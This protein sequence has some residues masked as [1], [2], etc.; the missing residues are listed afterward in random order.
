MKL[1]TLA[2]LVLSANAEEF[3]VKVGSSINS[4]L[5]KANPGDTVIL[6]DGVHKQDIK[7][8]R[9][10]KADN[11]ITIKGSRK[12]IVNGNKDSRM[13][14]I[15]HSYIQLE[16]F[17]ADG[18]Q[19]SGDKVDDFVD[20]GVYVLGTKKPE[21]IRDDKGEY[22]SSIDGFKLT[23]VHVLNFGGEC[24]RLRSFITNA[25][26]MGNMI[27]NCGV[28]DFQFPSSTVN[29]EAI[30]VGCSSNQWMDGKNSKPGPDLTKYIHIHHNEIIPRG[31]ECVDVKE[32]TTM[33]LVEYNICSEQ[34]DENSAGLD[35]RA[36]NVIF[37]Y[38]EV[39][40]VKGAGVRIGGHTIDGHTYGENNEV[41]GNVFFNTAY[42][43]VKTLTGSKHI[44]CENTCRDKCSIAGSMSKSYTSI[45][46]KCPSSSKMIDPVWTTPGKIL[47]I[48]DEIR[49]NGE[50]EQDANEGPK[51]LIEDEE[52][53]NNDKKVVKSD[54]KCSPVKI[55]SVKA[56]DHDGNTPQ[57]AIDGKAASRWST[58][59]IGSWLEMELQY[60]SKVDSVEMAF[61][62]GDTR[63][64]YFDVYGNGEPLIK[65]AKSSG[66]TLGLERF[67]IKNPKEVTKVTIFGNGNSKNSW[68]SL[69]EIIVCGESDTD[70][71]DH[72]SPD[73]DQCETK[74]LDIKGVSASGSD[75]NSPENVLKED[76]NRWSCKESPCELIFS[77]TGEEDVKEMSFVVYKGKD[78]IQYFDVE[79]ELESGWVTVIQDGSS[80]KN[81]GLQSVD[82][83]VSDV[84]SVKFIGYGCDVTD[85]NSINYVQLTGCKYNE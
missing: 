57:N 81:N 27:E 36:D 24:V 22:E 34:L 78:R 29:G 70:H 44:M 77:L 54:T 25:E 26:V 47:D 5:E 15:N 39:F 4:V 21:I 30:Y 23:N 56:S 76:N 71:T 41:Y 31:N 16:G 53:E 7:S 38:N 82:I 59:K 80:V 58:E 75:G 40:N 10:G 83:N 50:E 33:V 68:S 3:R 49:G 35:S 52:N 19:G 62:K 43:S 28:H 17:T 18:K 8:V 69:T 20:K 14:Q 85:W 45:D 79:V 63:Q 1:F 67:I 13:I 61:Y 74:R 11:Y 66:K 12:A 6:E 37:R 65:E 32:G 51:M 73:E 9:D 60:P 42:S 46:N 2:W 84:K 55:K 64:Q 48:I 72:D